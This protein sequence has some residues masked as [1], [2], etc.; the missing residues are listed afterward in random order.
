MWADQRDILSWNPST[1]PD[2]WIIFMCENTIVN[3]TL[4]VLLSNFVFLNKKSSVSE[5]SFDLIDLFP[6]SSNFHN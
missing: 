5:E 4:I 6:I 2:S 3:Q 1:N